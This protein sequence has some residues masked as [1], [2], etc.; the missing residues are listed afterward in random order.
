MS[1]SI[2]SKSR[3][4]SFKDQVNELL[5]SY[6]LSEEEAVKIG[7]EIMKS[8]RE[9]LHYDPDATTYKPVQA[10]YTKRWREKQKQ[11]ES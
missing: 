9:V 6:N 3:Y 1:V 8:F 4:R 7:E 10:Q 2:V 11:K 5:G